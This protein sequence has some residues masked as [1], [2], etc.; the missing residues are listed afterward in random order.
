MS[1]VSAFSPELVQHDPF[2]IPAHVVMIAEVGINH[3]GDLETAKR[4]IREAHLAGCDAVKFQKRTIDVV[5]SREVLAEP[6]ES[7]W[8]S[9]QRAQKEGLE[10]GRNEYDAIDVLCRELGIAWSASAWDIDS[11]RFLN[12]YNLA[13]NKVASALITNIPFLEVVA[14]EKRPTYISTGMSTIADIDRAVQIFR[15]AKCPF[16]LLHSVSTYPADEAS[17]N[18]SAMETLRNR[19]GVP[20]GYSGHEPSVSPSLVAAALGA[21]VIERHLTLDRS[22]YGSDQAASLEPIGMRNLVEMVRKVPR[23]IGDGSKDLLPAERPVAQK[24]RYWEEQ[25]TAPTSA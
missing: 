20:V 16:V 1:A 7:P 5:Y 25:P 2:P 23:L 11:Q 10:F 15:N 13:F 17:L 24:L 9:T 12:N 22:M 21:V 8:G 18:L 4:L 19:Y 3:N 14:A 6:R